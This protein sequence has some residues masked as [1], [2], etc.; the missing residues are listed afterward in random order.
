[1]SVLGW[2]FKKVQPKTRIV[3]A[4]PSW[5]P[6]SGFDRRSVVKRHEHLPRVPCA[7]SLV[8]L[9]VPLGFIT[10]T[11][12]DDPFYLLKEVTMNHDFWNTVHG[13][14]NI[15]HSND[16]RDK[17]RLL[18]E[19]HRQISD[20][21]LRSDIH[22]IVRLMDRELLARAEWAMYCVMQLR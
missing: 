7:L 5:N 18:L 20:P 19:M 11:G 6:E 9:F 3:Q 17:K 15:A 8:F 14:L 22:R 1:M 16:I 10:L 4:F 13:W 21:G 2:A 12:P